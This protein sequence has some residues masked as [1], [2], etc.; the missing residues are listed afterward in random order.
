MIV[1]LKFTYYTVLMLLTSK[2]DT[3]ETI[4]DLLSKGEID[5]TD[6][7]K[8]ISG[9]LHITKQGFYKALRELVSEEVVLKNKQMLLLNNVWINKVHDFINAVD[10][11]YGA[12]SEET[13][14]LEEGESLVYHF[15]T[16]PSLDAL[17]MHYFFILAK[18]YPTKEI[19]FFNAHEFWSLFRF[20]AE[21]FMYKWIKDNN[22]KT[23]LV[24]GGNTD[25]DRST[26][27]YIR[28]YGFEL[29]FEDK[30]SFNKNY[31]TTV[32]GD[33]V[34]DTILDLNTATAID[35]LYKAH[36]TWDESVA[37]ELGQ[38]LGKL[39]R[40]KVVLE[41]NPKKAERIKKKLVKYFAFK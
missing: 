22:Y 35:N 25:L 31:F 23:N 39:K 4:I 33:Y 29:A 41:R 19:Y 9:K 27:K 24:I 16:I 37:T 38:I 6:L 12:K 28:E 15:K 20:E 2:P 40:S 10:S 18:K 14:D 13:F 7:Q 30:P 8:M 32:I 26:T 3:K 5:S 11:A 34:L 1:N 36:K 21:S 17:W